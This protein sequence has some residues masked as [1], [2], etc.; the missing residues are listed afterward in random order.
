[1]TNTQAQSANKTSSANPNNGQAGQ[2]QTNNNDYINH[3]LAGKT[4]FYIYRITSY[5]NQETGEMT[6]FF[7]ASMKTGAKKGDTYIPCE[8]TLSPTAVEKLESIFDLVNADDETIK[9]TAGV[10]VRAPRFEGSNAFLTNED[11]QGIKSGELSIEDVKPVSISKFR[12]HN[13]ENML[14]FKKKELGDVNTVSP[15]QMM[16]EQ[17]NNVR[18]AR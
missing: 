14:L 17:V 18:N 15:K 11:K 8:G 6:Y 9:R 10:T 12:I 13:V 1:M 5:A 2:N 3:Y 16:E 4:I 7:K